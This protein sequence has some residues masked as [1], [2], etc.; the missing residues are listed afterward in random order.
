VRRFVERCQLFPAR[1]FRARAINEHLCVFKLW[2]DLFQYLFDWGG[3]RVHHWVFLG[4][5]NYF[6]FWHLCEFLEHRCAASATKK[7]VGAA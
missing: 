2:R 5:K 1:T 7:G 6:F 4:D 3:W